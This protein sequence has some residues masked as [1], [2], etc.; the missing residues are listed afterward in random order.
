MLHCPI[1]D[2]G[3]PCGPLPTPLFALT[4]DRLPSPPNPSS[5]A[6]RNV[7]QQSQSSA[8]GIVTAASYIGTAL[9][10]GL[11]PM[12]IQRH[13]WPTVF[14]LF[15]GSA[16]LWLPFWL[17]V[18]ARNEIAERSS[19]SASSGADEEGGGA[20]EASPLLGEAK[21]SPPSSPQAA[22][23]SAAG[24]PRQQQQQQPAAGIAPAAGAS[25]LSA[26]LRR[27]EVWAICACQYCQ[28]YGMY[29]LLTWLP[30]FFADYYGIQLGDLGGYTLLPYV[31]QVRAHGGG[32]DGDGPDGS[33]LAAWLCIPGHF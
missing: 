18:R 22:S 20:G 27:R 26:L 28:S 31:V 32:C 21:T 15:G 6:A 7:P 13:G 12:L 16:L 30:T 4:H 5:H 23:P 17:P 33:G 2:Q 29:G 8:V 9:A 3:H 10:F 19:G 24:T 11:A 14:Y 1:L 25:V